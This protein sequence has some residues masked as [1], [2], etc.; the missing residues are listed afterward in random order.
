V[1]AI[2]ALMDLV[3]NSPENVT[4]HVKVATVHRLVIV[5]PAFDMLHVMSL[6]S[7]SA[8]KTGGSLL[9][10]LS[11]MEH[12]IAVAVGFVLDLATRNVSDAANHPASLQPLDPPSAPV[13]NT[14]LVMDVSI[15]L[16]H[17]ILNVR[18]ALAQR[19]PTVWHVVIMQ[20]FGTLPASV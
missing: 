19:P 17:V 1:S 14:I 4:Q 9:T 3:A 6:A 15:M 20:A 8:V 5:K 13:L 11:T 10:A 7:A 2:L 12:A 18:A 16:E